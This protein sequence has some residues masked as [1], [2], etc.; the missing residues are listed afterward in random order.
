MVELERLDDELREMMAKWQAEG[1]DPNFIRT[2]GRLPE[3]IK[4]FVRFYSPLV[5]KGL[6]EHRTKELV[7]LRLAQ[8]NQCHY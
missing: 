6:V 7:R 5:R 4:R 3:T 8:L 1:G 2:F